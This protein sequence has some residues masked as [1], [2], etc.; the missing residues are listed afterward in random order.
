M[1]NAEFEEKDF[2]APLYNQ[3]L[4]GSHNLAT[5][6]QV[7]EG[8]FGIDAALQALH[9]LFWDLFGY[10]D[11][12]P[13]VRLNDFRWRFVWRSLGRKRQLP[14][15]S[16]NLLVQ[17]KRPAVLQRARGALSHLGIRGPFWRFKIREHQQSIL[18]GIARTLGNK[19]LVIYASPAF[20]TFD[21]LY[22]YTQNRSIVEKTNYV[23]VT[24]MIGH[25]QWNYNFPGTNGVALSEAEPIE[26][27]QFDIMLEELSRRYDL[28]AESTRELTLLYKSTISLCEE[29]SNR[30]PVARYILA[31]HQMLLETFNQMDLHIPTVIPFSGLLLIFS[32]VNLA[33]FI[34]GNTGEQA[35]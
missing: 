18:E 3:L 22:Q 27:D 34:V 19:A 20:D 10:P 13:G 24:R 33:W 29:I 16:V 28:Q 15:F 23:K 30:N 5:P 35:N 14:N 6:G 25:L 1:R 12:P 31:R 26:D 17:S 11:I 4:F 2:E 7:F 21:E 32:V 8:N 9:P